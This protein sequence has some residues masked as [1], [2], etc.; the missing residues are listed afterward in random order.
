MRGFGGV[1]ER[2]RRRGAAGIERDR[3]DREVEV[4]EFFVKSLPPGQVKGASSPRGP[5]EEK[6][7]FAAIVRQAM[8]FAVEVG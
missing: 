6:D 2:A 8:Q 3:D 1:D 7:F 4:L 5:G